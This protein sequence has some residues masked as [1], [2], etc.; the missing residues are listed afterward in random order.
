MSVSFQRSLSW[1]PQAATLLLLLTILSFLSSSCVKADNNIHLYREPDYPWSQKNPFD[2]PFNNKTWDYLRAVTGS[3][4]WGDMVLNWGR[5]FRIVAKSFDIIETLVFYTIGYSPEFDWQILAGEVAANQRIEACLI[6]E[7]PMNKTQVKYYR[8]KGLKQYPFMKLPIVFPYNIPQLGARWVVDRV[9]ESVRLDVPTLADIY[10]GLI[11]N[12]NDTRIVKLNPHLLGTLPN[13][14]I[15]PVGYKNREPSTTFITRVFWDLAPRFRKAFPEGPPIEWPVGDPRISPNL[16]LYDYIFSTTAVV[17]NTG[18]AVGY[19]SLPIMNAGG[20]QFIKYIIVDRGNGTLTLPTE[21]YINPIYKNARI[22]P[23]TN[24]IKG[25]NYHAHKSYPF[26]GESYLFYAAEKKMY[27]RLCPQDRNTLKFLVWTHKDSNARALATTAGFL[28]FDDDINNKVISQLEK[29]ECYD[30][31]YQLLQTQ[32]I[33]DH[34]SIAFPILLGVNMALAGLF[35][36]MGFYLTFSPGNANSEKLSE[37]IIPV[38]Y[39]TCFHLGALL[40]YLP[41]IFFYLVPDQDWVCQARMWLT[42]IG[43]TIFLGSMFTRTFQMHMLLMLLKRNTITKNMSKSRIKFKALMQFIMCVSACILIQVILLIVWTSV[44]PL[45]AELSVINE[46]ERT[47][48]WVCKGDNV[49]VWL[50]LEIGFFVCLIIYGI[51]VIYAIWRTDKVKN[52]KWMLMSIYNFLIIMAALIP[53]AAI[54]EIKDEQV[55]YIAA[56]GI[57]FSLSSCL[58]IMSLPRTGKHIKALLNLQSLSSNI[59]TRSFGTRSKTMNQST[60]SAGDNTND[61]G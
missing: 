48:S 44:D 25:V 35:L 51:F 21:E 29:L 3:S 54:I 42:G 7:R 10:M 49:W 37:R 59:S 11:T 14:T 50:G 24:A 23:E 9:T 60:L 39:D 47:A 58:F 40:S 20:G 52:A 32:V 6:A 57:A 30:T 28:Y 43:F 5:A 4:S 18:G 36:L 8:K 53:I 26:V 22:D 55:F 46:I 45:K 19:C 15:T 13:L 41:V 56:F 34:D 31:N 61:S 16:Q 27:R 1:L 33:D 12:W 2:V 17:E 38:L